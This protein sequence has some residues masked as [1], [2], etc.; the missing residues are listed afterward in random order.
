MDELKAAA[1]P[2]LPEGYESVDQFLKEARERF[3]QGV[4][5]DRENRDAALD[6]LKFLSGEGQWDP[7]V[8][9]ARL[10]KGQPC[11]TINTLPQHVGQVYGDTRANRPSIKVRPAEDGDKQIA[12]IRQGLI[13]FIENQ[14]NAT[15]VYSLAGEDQVACGIGHF[16][17]ALE[18]ADDETFN[19][20]MRVQ[21]IPNPLNVVWDPLSVEPTGKDARFCFVVDEMD[22]ETFKRR[23]PDADSSDL[24]VD[25][26][27]QGW[28]SRDTYRVTEYWVMKETRTTLEMEGR[29]RD[30]VKRSA[31]VYLT[32]GGKLL[33]DPV[34]YPISR[35]PIFKVTGRE[36]RMGDKRYR[37]GLIR[38]AKDPIRFKNIYRSAAAEWLAMS[39]KPKWLLNG[40]TA[41]H[42]AAFRNAHK[43]DDNVLVWEGSEKP[44]MIPPVPPPTA[45]LQQAE[46]ADQDIK[47]VTGLHDASLGM[48]SNE[49]S[50]KAIIARERQGDTA[51]FMYHDNLSLAVKECGRVINELLPVVYDTARTITIL[52]EDETTKAIRVNDPMAPEGMLDL[53]SGK[54]DIV[55][56][57]GPSYSTK[58]VEAAESMMQFLQAVPQAAALIGDLVAQN[59]D[60][61]GADAIA[62]RLK[63]ALP[64]NIAEPDDEDLTPEEMQ[65]RQMEMQAAQM[66]QQMQ[67]EAARLEL[68]GKA[69]EIEYKRAQSAKL[70]SEASAAGMPSGP[71]ETELD[72]A[73]K[74]EQLRKAKAEADKAEAEAQIKAVEVE[75]TRIGVMSDAMDLEDRPLERAH[76][77]AD[78]KNKL[79]PP[80]PKKKAEA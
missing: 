56:E 35:L 3:Q 11:L 75:K 62:E 58:R 34:E 80:E 18:Y 27:Q 63:K 19:Q 23:W 53:G 46:F 45:L 6:D 36:V 33:E 40:A 66:Q 7:R 25:L 61:P 26:K 29:K 65:R 12:E 43:S 4:D 51:T 30:V 64:P 37:F 67:Q 42:A 10:K 16:R 2:A 44:E 50:G 52:G 79:N 41:E 70:M 73:L 38:F 55:V 47:D 13:R 72:V 32:N 20:D 71:Q 74:V 21:Q 5:A 14:S 69:A 24:T 28:E 48:K 9:E 77:E 31:C 1:Q 54:Y 57:T 68:A 78:L 76:S 17:V 49:T 59:Q 39:P 22:K 60:W 8:K 15:H